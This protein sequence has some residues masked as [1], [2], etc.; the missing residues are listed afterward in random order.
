V[1]D[2]PQ[3]VRVIRLSGLCI[4]AHVRGSQCPLSRSAERSRRPHANGQ[5][6]SQPTGGL[7]L[8][9]HAD[10]ENLR[11]P[12]QLGPMPEEDQIRDYLARYVTV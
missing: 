7:R 9:P 6:R 2:A 5:C 12:S 3:G 4:A 8:R 1:T 10:T 11:T